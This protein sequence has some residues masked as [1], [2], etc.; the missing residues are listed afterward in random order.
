AAQPPQLGLIQLE[1][2]ATAVHDLAA[3][4]NGRIFLGQQAEDRKRRDRFA[5]ARFADQSDGGVGRDVEADAL[6]RFEGSVLVQA[7]VDPQVADGEKRF[8]LVWRS[9]A[10]L[11]GRMPADALFQL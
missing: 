4:K 1:Q 5:A 7:E 3:E 6:H 10:R 11:K 8:H 2:V 9:F